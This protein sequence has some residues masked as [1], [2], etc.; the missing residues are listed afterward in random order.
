MPNQHDYP[1]HPEMIFA[2]MACAF[3]GAI[4]GF[5]LGAWFF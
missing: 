2:Y 3:S 4:V 1:S 5:V